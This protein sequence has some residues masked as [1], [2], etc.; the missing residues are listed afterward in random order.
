[1]KMWLELLFK[2]LIFVMMTSLN[3][4]MLATGC[5]GMVS[6]TTSNP[7]STFAGN[8]YTKPSEIP[9]SQLLGDPKMIPADFKKP[10]TD[11]DLLALKVD[12]SLM[13]SLDQWL[14]QY[15]IQLP[16]SLIKTIEDM[17]LCPDK[18]SDGLRREY[19]R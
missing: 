16:N 15:G 9:L 14:G 10:L 4:M 12:K 18:A 19:T 5:K 7:D 2:P 8:N 1:M 3:Q 13:I 6:S 11:V 17:D